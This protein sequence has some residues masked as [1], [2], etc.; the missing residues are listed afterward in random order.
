[1]KKI[2][3]FLVMMSIA[4]FCTSC[5]ATQVGGLYADVK[6]GVAVTSNPKGSKVGRSVSNTYLGLFSTGDAGIEAAIAAGG[7]TKVSHVDRNV[8]NI[9]GIVTTF[10]TIVYG[11]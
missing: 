11:E 4:F 2:A 8:K 3:N 1:M 5:V 9:L 6:Q 7:I 10:E